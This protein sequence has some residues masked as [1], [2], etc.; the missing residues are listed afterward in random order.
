MRFK[1]NFAPAND[2]GFQRADFKDYNGD[3]CSIQES[4]LQSV[5]GEEDSGPCIWLGMNKGTHHH[6]TGDCLARMHLTRDM[7][8]EIA[9][10]LLRFADT[11]EL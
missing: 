5:E 1:L 11:G 2:R 9:D 7:A 8:R 3:A 6:I 10:A 4:S